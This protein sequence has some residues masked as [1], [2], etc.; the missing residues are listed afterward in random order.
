VLVFNS[1]CEYYY[2]LPIVNTYHA[3]YIVSNNALTKP[4][5]DTIKDL[6]SIVFEY[7]FKIGI[8]VN[9]EPLPQKN[10]NKNIT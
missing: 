1:L 9:G 4:C 7:K 5:P 10:M 6:Y 8:S 2:L 3:S